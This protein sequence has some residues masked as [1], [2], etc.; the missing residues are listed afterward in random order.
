MPQT[1]YSVVYST[2]D[3]PYGHARDVIEHH[4]RP[5]NFWSTELYLKTKRTFISDSNKMKCR[6][7]HLQIN[8]I[9]IP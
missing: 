6:G 9:H 1:M 2:T 3:R 5:T 4:C 8:A 7:I